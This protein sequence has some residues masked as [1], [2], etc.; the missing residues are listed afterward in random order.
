MNDTGS[1]EQDDVSVSSKS[2]MAKDEEKVKT[3]LLLRIKTVRMIQTVIKAYQPDLRNEVKDLIKAQHSAELLVK[4]DTKDI[5]KFDEVKDKLAY[6]QNNP[7]DD[8][9]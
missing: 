8:N 9:A 6:F 1:S 7:Y 2:E 3:L 5:L 4:E